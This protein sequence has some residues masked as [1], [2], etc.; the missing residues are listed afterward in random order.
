M[1][2][3]TKV[4]AVMLFCLLAGIS[5]AAQTQDSTD[6]PAAPVPAQIAGAKRVFISNGGERALFRLPKDA[7][8]KGGPNRTYNQFYSTMKRWGRY[9]LV[10]SPVDADLVFDIGF[11]DRPEAQTTVSEFQLTILDPKTGI[12]L[13]TVFEYAEPAGM[14]K[15]REKNY[16]AAMQALVEDL[17]TVTPKVA[18]AAK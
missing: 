6:I 15:N 7:W 18:P 4:A 17:K 14:A 5:F 1:R 10:S 8:Y 3:W 16:D 2:D 11:T 13:W 9:E 12:P